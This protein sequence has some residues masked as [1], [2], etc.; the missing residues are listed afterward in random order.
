MR[1]HEVSYITPSVVES[2]LDVSSLDLYGKACKETRK[3]TYDL[4]LG[5]REL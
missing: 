1:L 5:T 2:S 4:I 3:S